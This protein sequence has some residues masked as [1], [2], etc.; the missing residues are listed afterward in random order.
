MKDNIFLNGEPLGIP[1][2]LANK[3]KRAHLQIQLEKK[4]PEATIISIKL[5]IP[6]PIKNN[7]MINH[8]FDVGYRRLLRTQL[9]NIKIIDK[10]GWNTNTG[11]EEFL[12]MNKNGSAL[13]KLAIQFEDHDR[14]G[15]LFDVDVMDAHHSHYSR[16]DL[17]MAPRKCLI[18]HHNAKECARNRTH[19]VED[20]QKKIS[21]IYFKDAK[22]E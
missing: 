6:G 17:D 8:L 18:C 4:Y 12:V 16:T 21:E 19:S 20:L 11:K 7:Q 22:N 14:L 10:M 13:K 1:A 2:V 15:R 3:D 5:N 9:Y